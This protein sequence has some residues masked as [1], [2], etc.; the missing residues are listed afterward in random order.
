MLGQALNLMKHSRKV[1]SDVRYEHSGSEPGRRNKRKNFI[2]IQYAKR[3]CPSTNSKRRFFHF[4]MFLISTTVKRLSAAY[5]ARYS[6]R[7]APNPFYGSFIL[8]HVFSG[9][10]IR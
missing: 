2:I 3:D 8:I 1:Q 6:L 10:G 4:S 5:G 7:G 9:C